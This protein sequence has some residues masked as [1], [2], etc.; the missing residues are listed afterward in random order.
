M[1]ELHSYGKILSYSFVSLTHL[2]F[3]AGS[4]VL[5]LRPQLPPPWPW[6]WREI[7]KFSLLKDTNVRREEYNNKTTPTRII[8]LISWSEQLKTG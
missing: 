1:S 4:P 6:Q 3:L 8:R 5:L 2:L 7:S